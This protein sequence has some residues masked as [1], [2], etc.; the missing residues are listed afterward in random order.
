MARP[1]LPLRALAQALPAVAQTRLAPVPE[2]RH[3]APALPPSSGGAR[4]GATPYA[5]PQAER[6]ANLRRE[7]RAT[8]QREREAG[9]T[10]SSDQASLHRQ[11]LLEQMQK[12][13][14]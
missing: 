13:G 2:G 6:C 14:C 1:F 12:A 7:Y 11:D 4:F 3:T 8:R 10:T 5:D 9:T